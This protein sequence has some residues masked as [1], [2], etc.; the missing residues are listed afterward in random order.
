MA[1][2]KK[3]K[4]RLTCIVTKTGDDGSTGLANGGRTTK[5]ALRIHALGEV[6]ELNCALGVLLAEALPGDAAAFLRSVQNS[7]FDLGGE[8]ALVRDDVFPEARVAELEEA[9][10]RLA[11]GLPPLAEF[12]LPGGGRAGALAHWCRAACRRAERALVGLAGKAGEPV[13]KP[14]RR[15]LNRLSDALFQ[16]A[17]ALNRA[18]GRPE[19][20]WQRQA[21]PTATP[22]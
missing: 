3:P 20:L 2:A 11:E 15:Y 1:E 7:L 13:G 17:R 4:R 5:N 6:D 19:T 16:L 18:E 22:A 14:A 12:I 21:A 10:A 9:S 8:L